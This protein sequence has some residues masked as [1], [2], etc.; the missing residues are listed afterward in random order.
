MVQFNVS[1]RAPQVVVIQILVTIL[2]IIGV[3]PQLV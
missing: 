2:L 3:A 1:L